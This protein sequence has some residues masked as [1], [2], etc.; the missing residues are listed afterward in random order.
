MTTI[1]S[2]NVNGLRSVQTKGALTPLIEEL[3]PDIICLQEIRCSE[4]CK[5]EP[6]PWTFAFHSAET[7]GHSGTLISSKLPPLAGNFGILGV[8]RQ[9]G[10]VITLEFKDFYLVNVYTPNSGASPERYLYRTT[11]WDAAFRK[12]IQTLQGL[13]QGPA[14]TGKPVVIVGDLNVIPTALDT[15]LN[16]AVAGQSPPEQAGFA[17]LLAEC[18]LVDTF[19]ATY[20]TTRRNSWTTKVGRPYNVGCRLDYILVDPTLH[21]KTTRA[22]IIDHPGSDHLPIL[23]AF[24]TSQPEEGKA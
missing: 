17:T 12:H 13:S 5:W 20:P 19:R 2:W 6:Y 10:R 1:V 9:E 8:E 3:K 7:K 24:T 18:K 23:W 16:V 11:V 22:E 4:S 21:A 15:T 14:G